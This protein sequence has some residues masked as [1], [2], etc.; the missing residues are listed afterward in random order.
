[1]TPRRCATARS[2]LNVVV[3]PAFF[4]VPTTM[5]LRPFARASA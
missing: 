5:T 4:A 1:A 3:F 2:A